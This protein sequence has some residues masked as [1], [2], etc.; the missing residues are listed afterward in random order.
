MLQKF[1][2]ILIAAFAVFV[3]SVA[4]FGGTLISMPLGIILVGIGTAKP[5][6]TILAWLTGLLMALSGLKHIDWK[7]FGKMTG[8]MMIGVLLGILV[9]GSVKMNYLLVLYGAIIV[10]IGCWKLFVKNQKDPK[11]LWQWVSL[12][13]AGLMQGMFV[14]GGSFLVI[15]ATSRIKDKQVFRATVNAVWAVLNTVLI[16]SYALD[17]MLGR[18][19]L[20]L[21]AICVIPTLLAIWG[22]N[23]AAKHI[24]QSLFLKITYLV[25]IASGAV[26]LITN[27]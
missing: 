8:I 3:Q 21:S 23:A 11:P 20:S 26:L 4:G 18:D 14:S 5:V 25:L 17:G 6:L 2:F 22:A 19:V 1:F 16:I 27:L 15:Y 13:L 12:S 10:I 7:E 24:N 9:F